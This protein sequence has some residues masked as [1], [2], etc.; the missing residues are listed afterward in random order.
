MQQNINELSYE[1]LKTVLDF[2]EYI[3]PKEKDMVVDETPE[4][5]E[6]KQETNGWKNIDCGN[7]NT[8]QNKKCNLG[9]YLR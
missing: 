9:G 6:E 2:F 1:Q 7:S 5:Q 3:Y 8:D 4:I